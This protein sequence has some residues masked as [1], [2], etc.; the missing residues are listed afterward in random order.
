MAEHLPP[1]YSQAIGDLVIS[2]GY[3]DSI[4]LD[5]INIFSGADDILM[6]VVGFSHMQTT[7]KIDT[8]KA[9]LGVGEADG[10]PRPAKLVKMLDE[11][12]SICGFRNS[13]VHAYWSISKDGEVS[14][15]R[16]ESRGHFRR[17]KKPISVQE[18]GQQAERARALEDELRALRDHLLQNP[19]PKAKR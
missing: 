2:I 5:L 15:V 1:G 4:I 3:L 9:Y 8:L 14:S 19:H 18:I 7:S 11:A 17:L 10:K 6:V 16:Y 13:V 12:S